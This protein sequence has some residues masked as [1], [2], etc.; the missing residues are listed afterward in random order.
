[1]AFS[2]PTLSE[3]V[4]RIENDFGSR[5]TG[6]VGAILRRA[7]IKILSRVNAG[8]AHLLHGHLDWLALQILPDKSDADI[9]VRQA[10]MRGMARTE[11]VF[12]RFTASIA[13]ANG[14]LV[15]SGS[16]LVNA[17]GDEYT[18]DSDVT[19]AGGIGTIAATAA[20][21]GADSTVSP[22]VVLKFQSP[23][24]GITNN[25]A[26]VVTVTQDGVD[27]EDVE[28]FRARFLA[29]LADPP[30]G[31]KSSEYIGWAKEVSGVTRAWVSPRGLGPGTMVV[32]FV[33]DGDVSIIPDSGEV[34][35]VQAHLDAQAP[36]HAIVTA[37]APAA[38]PLNFTFS[39]IT[40][41]TP[42]VKTAVEA[43]LADMVFQAA[44]PRGM[45]LTLSRVRTT[46]GGTAG[47]TD[48]VLTTPSTD[49]VYTLNQLPTMGT[50]T[51][52]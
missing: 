40:P 49:M 21:A 36:A 35:A 15:P 12:V 27:L 42:E 47:V 43:E 9:L 16:I 33:R 38:T 10:S 51:W 41:N 20:V 39:S 34:A 24:S 1:M 6:I 19:V 52:P 37:V 2:R 5:V 28:V 29:R 26:T 31:G 48:Y 4:D 13:G 22:G 46:I 23:I 30:S 25:S 45:T 14:T 18:V 44:D 50:V 32:R 17:N 3:L 8:V 7:V 11:A